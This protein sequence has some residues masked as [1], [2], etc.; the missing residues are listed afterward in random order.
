MRTEEQRKRLQEEFD[1]KMAEEK[2]RRN[3]EC[4]RWVQAVLASREAFAQAALKRQR[5]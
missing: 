2:T 3:E 4:K 5:G 1:R